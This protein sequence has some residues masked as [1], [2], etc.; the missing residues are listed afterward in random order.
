MSY[1][2]VNVSTACITLLFSLFLSDIPIIGNR[3]KENK[4]KMEMEKKLK[5]NKMEDTRDIIISVK[6][7]DDEINNN[8]SEISMNNKVSLNDSDSTVKLDK[9]SNQSVN[10]DNNNNN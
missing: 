2:I 6:T 10:K 1:R 7:N 5:V 4:K 9:E 3:K 8:N